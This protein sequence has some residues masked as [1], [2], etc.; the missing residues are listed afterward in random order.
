MMRLKTQSLCCKRYDHKTWVTI[1]HTSHDA[2]AVVVLESNKK[3]NEPIMLE[4]IIVIH[5][6]VVDLSIVKQNIKSN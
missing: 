5:R 3:R 1:T 4:A 2:Y 6:V